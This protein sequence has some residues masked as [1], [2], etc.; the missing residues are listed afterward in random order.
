MRI[1]ILLLF[2]IPCVFSGCES[3]WYGTRND[4]EPIN[5]ISSLS[6]CAFGA[7]GFYTYTNQSSLYILIMCLFVNVG[8]S[9]FLHHI[10]VKN[11]L[12]HNMDLTSTY[13]IAS[14]SLFFMIGGYEN[15]VKYTHLRNV[16]FFCAFVL[17]ETNLIL[18]NL[19]DNRRNGVF[20][21]ILNCIFIA[22][23]LINVKLYNTYETRALSNRI[24]RV[25]VLNA[26]LFS[27]ASFSHVYDRY[28]CARFPFH[29]IW[30][31]FTSWA[32]FNSLQLTLLCQYVSEGKSYKWNALFPKYD[33]LFFQ[34]HT[35]DLI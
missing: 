20:Y 18:F 25:V 27:F 32:L 33:Y 3:T 17:A 23:V 13:L 30:H 5:A 22:Q 6:F 8:I 34:L 15:R 19:N 29:A 12:F 21:V 24:V 4:A 16:L 2:Y 26:F 7:V 35:T 9:S 1:G 10:D 11:Q 31:I 28:A 14:F